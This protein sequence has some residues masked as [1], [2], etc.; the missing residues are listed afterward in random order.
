MAVNYATQYAKELA[1]AYPYVLYSGRLWSIDNSKKY[2]VVDAKTIKIPRL[3]TTGRVDGDR[4]KIGDFSQNFSND[5]ETKELKNH[6]IWQTL[7]HP[8]DVNQTNQVASI[9]NITQTMNETQKFPELDAMMFSTLYT[10]KN[11]KTAITA[12]TAELT[13]KTALAKFDAMMDAMDEGLV[14]PT[15]RILYVDTFTKTL[16]DNAVAIVRTNGD[17]TLSRTVS[18]LD[19]VDIVGVPT[20]LM[21]TKYTFNDGK[22]SGQENG[23]ITA[24]EDAEDMA[25][26]LVHPSAILPIVSYSF[27]QLQDPS[28][29]TQGKYVYFE[30]SFEDVFILDKRVAA[31]QVCVKVKKAKT[32]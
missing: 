15:G 1:N 16:L 28:A 31:I 12:E 32:E 7:V 9:T 6:R 27:A 24:K 23:G 25:M 13:S 5:W 30:E 3:S 18:R 11:A 21:K 2:K 8:Q 4:T 14:P 10:L 20:A 26:L 22:T 19:E 17:K 29:L